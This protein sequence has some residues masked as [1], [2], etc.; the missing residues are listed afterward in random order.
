MSEEQRFD[1]GGIFRSSGIIIGGAGVLGF[2]VPPLMTLAFS[3]GTTQV[4]AD[5]DIYRF[6]YWA[7]AWG[8]T[9]LQGSWMLRHVGDRI[10]DDMLVISIIS[11]LGLVIL[12]FVIWLVYAPLQPFTTLDAGG[13]LLLIVVALIAAR[14]NRF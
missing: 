10:I 11:A 5:N 13:A 2:A 14:T 4:V 8:L 7:L 1:W 9:F 3:L 6:A 12:K